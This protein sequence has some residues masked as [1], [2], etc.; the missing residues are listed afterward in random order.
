MP[1]QLSGIGVESQHA[2]RVE[3]VAG[4]YVAVHVRSGISGAPVDQVQ[5][6]IVGAGDPSGSAAARPGV[7]APG[8]PSGIVRSGDGVEAPE[9]FS[10]GDVV[11]VNETAHAELSAGDPDDDLVFHH[12]RRD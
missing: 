12:Q 9:A 8:F 3:I 6:R 4:A 2:A 7:A 1:L 5:F 11:S 10:G